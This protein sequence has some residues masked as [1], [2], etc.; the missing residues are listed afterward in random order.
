MAEVNPKPKIERKKL[1]QPE[2]IRRVADRVWQLW[3][4]ELRRDR[5]RRSGRSG[6]QRR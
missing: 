1:D 4:E 5:E 3:R 2:L 6:G